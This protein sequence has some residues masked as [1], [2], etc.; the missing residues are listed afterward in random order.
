VTDKIDQEEERHSVPE[1]ALW[2][3]VVL[4]LHS[5]LALNV[6]GAREAAYYDMRRHH[7]Y[8]KYIVFDMCGLQEGE[9]EKVWC[10]LVELASQYD[11]EYSYSVDWS[12]MDSRLWR[13]LHQKICA[14]HNYY[15]H[16]QQPSN[17]TSL[18]IT[19]YQ[20]FGMKRG[21]VNR[22]MQERKKRGLS[23]LPRRPDDSC[24]R[25]R[26]SPWLY[27]SPLRGEGSGQRRTKRWKVN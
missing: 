26:P 13:Y 5:D 3:A 15:M 17:R 18:W 9:A 6:D 20:R 25:V 24:G 1:C 11:D 7:R 27:Y 22:Y 12:L 10:E 14:V 2:L 23:P 4:R 8:I 19:A 16:L 21:E